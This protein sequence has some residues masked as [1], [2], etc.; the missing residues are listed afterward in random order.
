MDHDEMPPLEMLR[1]EF[2][3]G[4]AGALRQEMNSRFES[5]LDEFRDAPVRTFLPVLVHR[6]LRG[7]LSR[8]H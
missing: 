5:V 1:R 4:A 2:L 7:E 6:R 8:L 3:A